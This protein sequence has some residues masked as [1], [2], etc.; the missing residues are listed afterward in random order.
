MWIN[1]DS[2]ERRSLEMRINIERKILRV[3]SLPNYE[4][5]VEVGDP[6]MIEPATPYRFFLIGLNSLSKMTITMLET[7]REFN[8]SM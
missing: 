5:V 1:D 2:L 4:S 3:G 7:V 8:N 6:K